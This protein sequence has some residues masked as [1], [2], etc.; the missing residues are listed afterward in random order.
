MPNKIP[1]PTKEIQEIYLIQKKSTPEIASIYGVGPATIQ[2]LLRS[3]G[4]DIRSTSEAQKQAYIN[5]RV[6]RL[7]DGHGPNWKGGRKM[8]MGYIEV[9]VGRKQY[10]KEHRLVMEGFLGRKLRK[11]ELVHHKNGIK[12]D[13]R[14]ENLTIVTREHHLGEVCCP[15]CN[16]NFHIK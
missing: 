11:T 9:L 13:N 6:P 10:M 14:I 7:N 1:L 12:T 3:S 4:V 2:R 16:H 8:R 5:G 15:K